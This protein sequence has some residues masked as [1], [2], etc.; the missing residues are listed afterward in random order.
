MVLRGARRN[1]CAAPRP[2]PQRRPGGR[3][4]R[5]ASARRRRRRHRL[6]RLDRLRWRRFLPPHPSSRVGRG[7][8]VR[9]R[10]GRVDVPCV[11]SAS[12]IDSVSSI[13]LGRPRRRL[14]C[15]GLGGLVG[16]WPRTGGRAR[17]TSARPRRLERLR[18]PRP[19]DRH[20]RAP[21]RGSRRA[22]GPRR[23]ATNPPACG[24]STSIEAGH[25]LDHVG[26]SVGK[27]GELV[28]DAVPRRRRRRTRVAQRRGARSAV[29]RCL[30]TTSRCPVVGRGAP[31]RQVL[32]A[33]DVRPTRCPATP[34]PHAAA[35][36][37][38][39]RPAGAPVRPQRLPDVQ[40]TVITPEHGRRAQSMA[41]PLSP[42]TRNA[43]AR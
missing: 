4:A 42:N 16:A 36:R 33:L 21:E 26:A 14:A 12:S 20:R 25:R 1:L 10:Q 17:S 13:V 43:K 19:A 31:A 9:R 38:G 35:H 29:D 28:A 23:L 37:A 32:H 6:D 30:P 39:P 18:C 5:R 8:G 40:G 11:G 2:G 3:A 41:P 22:S 34:H 27:R 7:V 24:S 15:G